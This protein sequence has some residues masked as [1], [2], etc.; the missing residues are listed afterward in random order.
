MAA[1]KENLR[2]KLICVSRRGFS[3]VG[4]KIGWGWKRWTEAGLPT[5]RETLDNLAHGALDFARNAHSLG[6]SY[7]EMMPSCD[8]RVSG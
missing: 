7:R 8:G 6:S 1:K 5:V 4:T 2:I 3:T